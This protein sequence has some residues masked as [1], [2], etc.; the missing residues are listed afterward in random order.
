MTRVTTAARRFWSDFW[1]HVIFLVILIGMLPGIHD[2]S[3]F[4]LDLGSHIPQTGGSLYE[5]LFVNNDFL[6]LL[7][8][9]VL[10]GILYL[11]IRRKK[12][13]HLIGLLP[14]L[15]YGLAYLGVYVIC[16]GSPKD[17]EL[18]ITLACFISFVYFVVRGRL[19]SWSFLLFLLM[20]WIGLSALQMGLFAG[21]AMALRFLFLLFSQNW[22]TFRELGPGRLISAFF[23]SFLLWSPM[24]LV[25]GFSVGGPISLY[26]SKP[27]KPSMPIVF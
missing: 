9:L 27:L 17:W 19:F 26:K 8:F 6:F 25:V 4:F 22:E 11:I 23:R 20:V 24:L 3:L 1:E 13:S 12:W 14:Y 7:A 2:Y 5:R 21:F 10:P 15:V 16:L 18:A